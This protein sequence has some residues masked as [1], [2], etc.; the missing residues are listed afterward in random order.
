MISYART[1]VRED[2]ARVAGGKHWEGRIVA[3]TRSVATEIII[4]INTQ[5]LPSVLITS[6]R[7]TMLINK[8]NKLL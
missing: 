3:G 2:P 4:N 6:V 5:Q 7:L 8:T 1:P